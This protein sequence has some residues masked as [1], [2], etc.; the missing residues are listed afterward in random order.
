ME[1]DAITR[2][3]EE[4]TKTQVTPIYFRGGKSDLKR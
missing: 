2:G 3:N 4:E 1:G